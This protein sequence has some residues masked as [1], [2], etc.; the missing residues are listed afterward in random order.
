M[1]EKYGVVTKNDTDAVE[2]V[3]AKPLRRTTD[4]AHLKRCPTCD[5][6]LNET[7][8]RSLQCP[9]CGTSPFEH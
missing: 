7:A 5:A 3:E 6:Q 9:N 8:T 4:V 1:G 2:G